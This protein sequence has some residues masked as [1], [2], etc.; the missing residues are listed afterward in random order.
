MDAEML[1]TV[2]YAGSFLRTVGKLMK[3]IDEEE[4]DLDFLYL[5]QDNLRTLERTIGS[6]N[7]MLS[8]VLNSLGSLQYVSAIIQTRNACTGVVSRFRRK[9]SG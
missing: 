9:T 7:I 5:L 1:E 2:R 4:V 3:Q 8:A 6:D